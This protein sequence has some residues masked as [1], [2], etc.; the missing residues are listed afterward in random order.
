MTQPAP[1]AQTMYEFSPAQNET[2]R[3]LASRMKFVG[4]FYI[5]IAVLFG[6]CGLLALF[7]LPP[8]GLV[9]CLVT[10]LY[11]LIG[12]WTNNASSSFKMI[13]ETKGSDITH[14]MSALESLRKLYNLQFW[15]LIVSIVVFVLA[16]VIALVVGIGTFTQMTRPAVSMMM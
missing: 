16:I 14:L 6:V 13:V 8:V 1:Q 2:I 9:Y 11:L 12:I 3:V 10:V 15:L 5:V 4:I 7:F